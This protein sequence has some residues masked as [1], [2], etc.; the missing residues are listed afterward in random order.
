[1]YN[2]IY[3]SKDLDSNI[4][5]NVREL[6]RLKSNLQDDTIVFSKLYVQL[7]PIIIKI[8]SYLYSNSYDIDEIEYMSTDIV[9]KVYTKISTFDV[10]LN[11]K[12]W[13]YSIVKNTV[14]DYYRQNK[15][16]IV[17]SIDSAGDIVD[18]EENDNELLDIVNSTI[19]KLPDSIEKSIFVDHYYHN[20]P[21]INLSEKY[22]LEY[23]SVKNKNKKFKNKLRKL[24]EKK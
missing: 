13:L 8:I 7:K 3:V 15:K 21:L 9:M 12:N 2:N 20:I 22:D 19:N 1:M 17:V 5:E 11:F 18:T 16:A 10:K 23:T 6:I 4:L 24:I 14:N